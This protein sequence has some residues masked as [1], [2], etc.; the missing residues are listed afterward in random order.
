MRALQV[1]GTVLNAVLV[2]AYPIAIFYGL[3]HFGA[4]AVSVMVLAMLVP[5]LAW[6]FRK[7]DRATFWSMVRLPIAISMLV[8][9]G[10]AT[11]D[12]R[13]VLALPVL[14]NAVLFVE[15]GSTL[16]AG[17]TPMIERF[18]RM[19]EPELDAAK[20]G[21]CRQWTGAWC[22]F[23]LLNGA[24]AALLAVLAPLWWWTVYTGGIAYALMGAMLVAEYTTRR[25]RF[26]GDTHR[27]S[28]RPE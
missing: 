2:I 28:K 24:A 16:R 18:A 21:H 6:R 27:S 15:F 17:A 3:T 5:S 11:D 1:A 7:A 19:R 4:R 12:R 20:V 26:P 13:F 22:A 25:L 23:F 14:I 9:G 8:I 10:I